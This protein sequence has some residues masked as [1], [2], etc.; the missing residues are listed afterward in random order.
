[1][2]IDKIIATIPG[3]NR[4]TRAGMRR[5]ALEK[6]E[7]GDP[8]WQEPARKLLAALDAQE[9]SEHADLIAEVA[10]LV[11][12]ER[13]LKA[14]TAEP[15]TETEEKLIRVLLDNPG[16]TSAELTEKMGWKAMAWHM[17]F[18]TMCAERGVY[19]GPAPDAV[20]RDGKFYSGIL[21]DCDN[22]NRFTMKPDVAAAFERLGVRSRV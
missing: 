11:P 15:M 20:V 21:A 16:S 22:T 3:A 9:E 2:N 4:D 19:L 14:F 13:V 6:L 1:M 5:N 10:G 12:A 7:G 18:G 8:A 17:K